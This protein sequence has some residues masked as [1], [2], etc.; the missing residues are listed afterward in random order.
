MVG[1]DSNIVLS[2][3]TEA[4]AERLTGV[5]KRQLRIWDSQG[6]FVPSL[7]NENRRLPYSRLYSF[8]DLVSLK[9]LNALRNDSKVPLSELKKVKATLTHMG[10]DV[11][12][13]T[14]L[15]VH[16][17]R[18]A[19]L[20]PSSGVKE[21]VVSGQGLLQ[22][23]LQV[24]AGDM[25]KAV[26]NMRQR[27]EDVQ[28][29]IVQHRGLMHN[30]PVVAGTRIPVRSIKAFAEAGYKEEEILREYPSLTIEDVRAAIK[31]SD[32]A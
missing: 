24:V 9:V 14:T 26:N 7:A 12:S 32:A 11:W 21:E 25:Q 29:K 10:D 30:R 16:D 2:A 19:F 6:F 4:Q 17:K 3:F 1:P 13:Q 5:S 27:G 28:G 31:H 20:N 23:V 15:Y 22:I 18:V 8:R